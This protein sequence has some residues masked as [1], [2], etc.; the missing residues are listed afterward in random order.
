MGLWVKA[1]YK[2]VGGQKCCYIVL[3]SRGVHVWISTMV[4]LE[5][6]FPNVLHNMVDYNIKILTTK[7]IPFSK[8]YCEIPKYIFGKKM[9]ITIYY[10]MQI[11]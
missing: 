10:K 1:H 2:G 3:F 11:Y 4:I 9:Y 8:L 7:K 6:I 5:H